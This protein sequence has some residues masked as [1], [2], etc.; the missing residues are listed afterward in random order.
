MDTMLE[1]YLEETEE[2]M[3]RAEECVIRLEMEY[4]AADINELFRIAHT[5][6]G[7]S[8]MAGFEDIGNLM[9]K[10]EDMLDYARKDAIQF[11]QSVVSLCFQA[12]D[13][14][15][16]ML[17]YKRDPGTPED[18]SRLVDAA[19]RIDEM[20]G[21]FIRAN[22]KDEKKAVVQQPDT[23]I[24][25]S[26]L[27]KKP[28]GKNRYYITFFIEEDA[29]M[30]SPVFMMILKS[31]GDIGSLV[32]SSVP[33]EYFSGGSVADGVKTLEI[34]LDTDID[35]VELY[36]YFAI[37]YVDRINVV[38]LSRSRLLENDVYFNHTHSISHVIILKALLKLYPLFL[39]ASPY[40]T[41]KE[42]LAVIQDFQ[43]EADRAFD[44][45]ENHKRIDAFVQDFN[46]LNLLITKIHQDNFGLDERQCS[47]IR[48]Q[49]AKLTERA[50]A[51]IRGKYLF[52]TFKPE[53]DGFIN[54]L[55]TFVEFMDKPSTLMVFI[56]TRELSIIREKEI[57]EL[58]GIKRR[59]EAQDV[60]LAVIVD[61]PYTRRIMNIFDSIGSLQEFKVYGNEL[62][63]VLAMSQSEEF[64]HK[65]SRVVKEVYYE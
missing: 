5:I 47:N 33:D 45:I 24:I 38:D 34:I 54:R 52:T 36:T 48:T 58:I 61:G 29:P 51:R 8:H 2:L 22:K 18:M 57:K 59:L 64:S 31:V 27:N 56:D 26:L 9:H 21:A 28:K 19:S 49:I 23:G 60:E 20:V 46:Q 12:L 50:Y 63:A 11:D 62:D 40:E 10:M 43:R 42:A 13:T 14:V 53:K 35:E 65:L 1:T 41:T 15:K 7:S 3:Q 30:V 44:R 25:S 17:G 16:Q 39:K 4:S 55:K 32:Y 37:N 6:K